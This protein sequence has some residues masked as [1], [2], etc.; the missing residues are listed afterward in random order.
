MSGVPSKVIIGKKSITETFFTM[1]GTVTVDWPTE[2]S[3]ETR[4]T[5]YA[6]MSKHTALPATEHKDI[7]YA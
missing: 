6:E 7:T 2:L 4:A 1:Y 3:A 5:V